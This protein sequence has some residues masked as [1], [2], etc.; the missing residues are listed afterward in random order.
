LSASEGS[1]VLGANLPWQMY[2]CDFG[3]NAWQPA[4]GFGS[5]DRAAQLDAVLGPLRERGLR[6]LRWF[7]LC[8]GRSGLELEAGGE[9][10]GLD[11]FF[12]RDF[13]AALGL[14]SRHGI[15][16][17]PVLLDFLW[18]KRGRAVDGVGIHG[19]RALVATE[20]RREALIE[21]VVRPILRRYATE[22]V[23]AA[24]DVFNEPEWATLGVGSANPSAS[25][26]PTS[27]RRLL[28]GLLD[29]VHAEARQPATVGLAGLDG[30]LIVDGL[31]VDVLQLHWYDRMCASLYDPVVWVA[32]GRPVLLGEFPTAHTARGPAETISRARALGYCGALGWSVLATDEFSSLEALASALT[33][34]AIGEKALQVTSRTRVAGRCTGEPAR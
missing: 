12:F 15:A 3:A 8:D 11:R 7:V 10:A 4:G 28:E 27:M 26:P 32:A 31:P 14:A 30:A 34:S 22:P 13:E 33:P 5:G 17:V 6:L 2:G 9:V 20:A 25:L 16:L 24:W 18:C 1:F 19:R 21:R 29:I 23:I